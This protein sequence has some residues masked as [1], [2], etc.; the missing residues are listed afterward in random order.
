MAL[1]EP[2]VVDDGDLPPVDTGDDEVPLVAVVSIVAVAATV[3]A[4]IGAIVGG[5][6]LSPDG[7]WILGVSAVALLLAFV[8]TCVVTYQRRTWA[9]AAT[10]FTGVA[11]VFVIVGLADRTAEMH[12]F[13]ETGNACRIGFE[14]GD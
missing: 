1:R 7:G 5:C 4:L 3:L 9:H 8:G 12:R 6:S 2:Y 13:A 11:F 10:I 14:G